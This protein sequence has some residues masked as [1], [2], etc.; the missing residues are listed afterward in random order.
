ML[1]AQHGQ[2]VETVV[3]DKGDAIF[4]GLPDTFIGTLYHSWS[5]DRASLP[6]DLIIT[7]EMRDGSI[8]G[9]RHRKYAVWGLQFH[10]ESVATEYGLEIIRNWLREEWNTDLTD[11]TN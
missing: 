1:T 10:P 7:A 2:T 9:L 11:A 3:L 8:M 6:A 4:K 5:V